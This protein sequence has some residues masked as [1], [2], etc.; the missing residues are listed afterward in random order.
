MHFVLARPSK[1]E[2]SEKKPGEKGDSAADATA[3]EEAAADAAAAVEAEDE[4]KKSLNPVTGSP[5]G[6]GSGCG[7]EKFPQAPDSFLRA[8]AE[9]EFQGDHDPPSRRPWLYPAFCLLATF[10]G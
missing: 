6:E 3:A 7:T 4:A 5:P 2:V 8:Q 9:P 10:G 1:D